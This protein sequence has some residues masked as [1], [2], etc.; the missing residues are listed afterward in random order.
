M[1]KYRDFS[2]FSNMGAFWG[3]GRTPG[4]SSWKDSILAQYSPVKP[5]SSLLWLIFR[6]PN[7]KSWKYVIFAY[8]DAYFIRATNLIW[9]KPIFHYFKIW[10]WDF[11]SLTKVRNFRTWVVNIVLKWSLS[12]NFP[13]AFDLFPQKPPCLK[14]AKNHGICTRSGGPFLFEGAARDKII[15]FCWTSRGIVFWN[16]RRHSYHHFPGNDSF[17]QKKV[18]VGRDLK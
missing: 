12:L 18:T 14:K 8:F 6:N 5:S 17:S 7:F 16:K 15:K 9:N 13:L 2:P 3:K 1:H 11:S 10:R 4:E